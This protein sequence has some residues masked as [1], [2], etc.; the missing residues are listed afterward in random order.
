MRAGTEWKPKR[1]E[2]V[3]RVM[4]SSTMALHV[5]TDEGP[6]ILKYMGNPQGDVALCCELIGTE[7]A[8]AVGLTT[9]P[10]AIVSVPSL[11]VPGY[12]LVQVG[13]GPAFLSRWETS[14]ALST[15]AQPKLLEAL[16]NPDDVSTLVAFDTWVRNK[17]RF[18]AA[19]D[20]QGVENRENLLFR[21]DKRKSQMIVIDHSHALVE[22]T[23]EDEMGGEWVDEQVVYGRFPQFEPLMRAAVVR[24]ALARICDDGAKSAGPVCEATPREW[25]MTSALAEQVADC[26]RKRAFRLQEWLLGSLFDQLELEV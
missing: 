18:T 2:R 17:D 26:L 21:Q 1:V 11:T 13:A 10:F 6:A 7:L 16:R 5:E 3:V 25:G 24:Q 19:D 12:P 4:Q 8:N 14:A 22:T 9:P 15:A 23:L 20:G